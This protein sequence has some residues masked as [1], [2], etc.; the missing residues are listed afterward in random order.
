MVMQLGKKA[1]IRTKILKKIKSKG[2]FSK[3]VIPIQVP[4]CKMGF[5]NC[6]ELKNNNRNIFVNLIM[7][8]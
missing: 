3:K 1:G 8:I 2:T 6:F 7:I 5:F 4:F